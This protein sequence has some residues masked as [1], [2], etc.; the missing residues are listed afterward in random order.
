MG[1][2]K[3]KMRYEQVAAK[4]KVQAVHPLQYSD[5]TILNCTW[6]GSPYKVDKKIMKRI[7]CQG[8]HLSMIGRII[9]E[10]CAEKCEGCEKY[11]CP[12]H[13]NKHKC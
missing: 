7:I 11:F 6:C 12:K 10:Q 3:E 8:F 13:I 2:W 4:N 1:Y 9:C 5:A